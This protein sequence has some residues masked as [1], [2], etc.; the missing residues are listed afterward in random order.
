VSVKRPRKGDE[1][2]FSL[3]YG[4]APATVL[5]RSGSDASKVKDHRDGRTRIIEDVRV[6][7]INGKLTGN[8]DPEE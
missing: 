7:Y 6:A 3:R 5:E 8:E 2:R 1:I 4:S